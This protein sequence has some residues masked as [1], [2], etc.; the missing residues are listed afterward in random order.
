MKAKGAGWHHHGIYLKV[1]GRA[2]LEHGSD[3]GD[4]FTKVL[5]GRALNGRGKSNRGAEFVN[6][7]LFPFL[8][9]PYIT[10]TASTAHDN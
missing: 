4:S 2:I 5:N 7:F 3:Y 10:L 1:E 9:S 8:H 6:L